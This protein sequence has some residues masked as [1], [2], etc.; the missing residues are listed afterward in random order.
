MTTNLHDHLAAVRDDA[1]RLIVG[2]H[3]AGLAEATETSMRVY[4]ETCGH[5]PS[6]A[7]WDAL[8]AVLQTLDNMA[9]GDCMSAL[10]LSAIDPGVGKT[11]AVQH[12]ARQLVVSPEHRDVG[13]LICVGRINE[14]KALAEALKDY[15][16]H[17]AVLTSDPDANALGDA[18]E[19]STAQILIITQQRVEMLTDHRTFGTASGLFYCGAPRA[20]RVWDEAFLWGKSATLDC[21]DLLGLLKGLSRMSP[22]CA[23]DVKA[24]ADGLSSLD[25]DVLVEVPDFD[26]LHGGV[27]T[28]LKE[29]LGESMAEQ[30]ETAEALLTMCGSAARV[31]SDG[32]R[33]N[34]VLS[35]RNTLPDDLKPL[36]VL[37][38][39][40]RVR[41]T[42]SLM[43]T[44]RGD[45]VNLPS[46]EKDYSPMT[47]GVWAK[48]GSKAGFERDGATLVKG[49][50]ETILARPDERWLVVIHR[51]AWK[52]NCERDIRRLLKGRVGDDLVTFIPWGMHQSRN[53]CADIGNVILAGTLF[54]SESYYRALSYLSQDRPMTA[55]V[56]KADVDAVKQ[57]EHAHAILQAVCRGRVRKSNGDRCKPQRTYIIA[58]KQSG[59]ADD[60]A[61][62]FPGCRV[63]PWQP[64]K[65]ALKGNL[66]RAVDY[67]HK[68]FD[69]GAVEV[70]LP[71]VR[72]ALRINDRNFRRQVT[73]KPAW[74]DAIGGLGLKQERGYRGATV[75][76]RVVAPPTAA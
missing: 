14:A 73:C 36:L 16:E 61:R 4:F 18:L 47:V 1:L 13:V 35:Y 63:E 29:A 26:A 6:D 37:D 40:A 23:A 3:H 31:Q 10:Y 58:S 48:S 66:K 12:W 11:T 72:E 44:S 5:R 19:P 56:S 70:S 54:F 76:R 8:R 7:H 67:V 51:K 46:A 22:Q 45:V 17:V 34:A 52:R 62:I 53:D 33:G 59:I 68:A 24:F 30:R 71:D 9:S 25:D 69:G 57:G 27:L 28:D 74:R 21:Y 64:L 39:S 43:A 55:T 42:Y 38:A 49:I 32:T 50:A 75:L 41:A 2:P 20:V 65:P 15:R 60:L